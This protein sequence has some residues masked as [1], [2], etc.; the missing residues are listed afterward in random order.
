MYGFTGYGM[1]KASRGKVMQKL[2]MS[3]KQPYS[4]LSLSKQQKINSNA[5]LKQAGK[6][7][8]AMVAGASATIVGAKFLNKAI[9][10]RIAG[11][12]NPAKRL[13]TGRM[14]S[15]K[16]SPFRKGFYR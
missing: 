13:A 15:L 4:K 9:G 1:T 7:S 11:M 8:V 2:G 14:I 5:Y 6:Y 3:A 16:E 10:I 12:M